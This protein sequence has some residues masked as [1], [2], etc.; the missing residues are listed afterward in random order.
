ME[1]LEEMG[2]WV[3]GRPGC[4]VEEGADADAMKQVEDVQKRSRYLLCF[5]G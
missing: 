1:G 5:R 3:M 2:V 4:I